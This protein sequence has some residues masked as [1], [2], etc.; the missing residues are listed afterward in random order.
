MSCPFTTGMRNDRV[1]KGHTL[2]AA[3]TQHLTFVPSGTSKPP[4][5]DSTQ[6]H[7]CARTHLHTQHTQ[8]T[9]WHQLTLHAAWTVV[10]P[11]V[12]SRAPNVAKCNCTSAHQKP[13]GPCKQNLGRLAC[14][15][16]FQL[17]ATKVTHHRPYRPAWQPRAEPAGGSDPSRPPPRC[18]PAR[19][20]PTA[21]HPL[22]CP[23]LPSASAWQPSR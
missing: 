18:H 17:S 13:A 19:R 2:T 4:V 7:A 14:A 9:F 8:G 15:C 11:L 10:R 21:P 5:Q 22:A 12:A 1:R 23:G 20:W 3:A 16:G 6:Q